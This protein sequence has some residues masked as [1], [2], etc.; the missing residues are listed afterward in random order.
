MG[1]TGTLELTCYGRNETTST[2][3]GKPGD[4]VT[5]AEYLNDTVTVYLFNK[6]A[7]LNASNMEPRLYFSFFLHELGHYMREQQGHNDSWKTQYERDRSAYH[8]APGERAANRYAQK[9]LRKWWPKS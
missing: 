5:R 8:K 6:C 7:T 3:N 4:F 9:M 1:F 2:E